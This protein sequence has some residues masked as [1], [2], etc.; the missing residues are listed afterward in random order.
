MPLLLYAAGSPVAV[1]PDKPV[2]PGRTDSQGNPS[3][4][5]TWPPHQGQ[6]EKCR[7]AT[8]DLIL[9]GE[10]GDQPS[11]AQ[12]G[13]VV[14]LGY[15]QLLDLTLLKGTAEVRKQ[16]VEVEGARRPAGR[17][18]QPAPHAGNH[19][20]RRHRRGQGAPDHPRVRG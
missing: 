13:D 2:W 6:P 8:L 12:G 9:A 17:N 16:V 18:P 20:C 7:R 15:L 14:A 1:A 5:S 10:E 3:P 11:P 19:L 4:P